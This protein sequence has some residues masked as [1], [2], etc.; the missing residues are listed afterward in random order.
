MPLSPTDALDR[1]DHVIAAAKRA[2][3]DAADAVLIEESSQSISWRMGA[4]EDVS[5]SE[6]IDLGLRVFRGQKIAS[7]SS[8]D[9]SA[10]ALDVMVE[11]AVAMAALAPEDPYAGLAETHLL[12]KAPHM[13][14][15]LASESLPTTEQLKNWAAEAEDAARAVSGVTNSEGAGAGSGYGLIALATSNGFRGAYASTSVSISASVI[16]ERDGMMERDYAYHSMRHAEDLESAKSIGTQAGERSVRRLGAIKPESALMPVVFDRRVSGSMIGHLLGAISGQSIARKSSFLQD[17]MGKP[18]FAKGID[19]IDDPLRVR[20]QRSRSFDA[21]GLATAKQLLV[22]DGVLQSWLLDI[23]S[24][25]QLGL[26]PNGHASRGVSSPPS[27]GASNVHMAAGAVTPQALIADIKRGIYVTEMIG[28]GVNGVTG[29]Y[30]RGAV[31]FLIENG[32][33]TVPVNEITIASTL[34]DMFARLVPADD[35]EFRFGVNAP[36]LR[37]DGMSIAGA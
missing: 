32:E 11:R 28:S 23:A 12:T 27:P 25:R 26:S 35:L 37:I 18:V 4:L 13:D 36:T 22:K 6:G 17:S 1:L 24:A 20:G 9:L 8:S 14:L 34:Q 15:Q 31:G 21:E 33:L 30:S 16:A 7:V 2:G 19:I 29:D 3:A 10:R 5:R